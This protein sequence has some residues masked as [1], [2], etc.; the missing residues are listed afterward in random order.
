MSTLLCMHSPV[1]V[2]LQSFFVSCKDTV[3]YKSRTMSG[4]CTKYRKRARKSNEESDIVVIEGCT[5]KML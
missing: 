4:S 3:V 1:H 5:K 2:T